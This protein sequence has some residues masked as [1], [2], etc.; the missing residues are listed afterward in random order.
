MNYKKNKVLPQDSS[1]E[2]NFVSC[3]LFLSPKSG[4]FRKVIAY[5]ILEQ[6]LFT[7]DSKLTT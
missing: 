3:C 7:S 2:A 4:L 1:E 6:F 5:G